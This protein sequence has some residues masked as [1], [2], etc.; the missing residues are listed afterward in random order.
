MVLSQPPSFAG[1]FLT[2]QERSAVGSKAL[3]VGNKARA[4]LLKKARINFP[5]AKDVKISG[6][7]AQ[8]VSDKNERISGIDE[9]TEKAAKDAFQDATETALTSPKLD[10]G[11]GTPFK[12]SKSE[13]KTA[14]GP[15]FAK[16]KGKVNSAQATIQGYL[17]EGIIGVMGNI[18][19]LS[20]IVTGKL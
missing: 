15:L 10:I 16:D 19:P 5:N 9:E 6:S 14:V 8:F 7:V 12:V 3:K 1:L 4:A 18:R 2:G 17:L 11:N 13:I 20:S